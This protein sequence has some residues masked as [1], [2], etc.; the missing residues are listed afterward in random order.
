MNQFISVKDVKNINALVAKALEYKDGIWGIYA[1]N[2]EQQFA[3]D[4]LKDA[5]NNIKK[6]N[7]KIFVLNPTL[8]F[9]TNT[10][11]KKFIMFLI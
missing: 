1:K 7:N 4:I 3:L 8:F 11:L 6:I 9:S 10:T 5:I 2:K